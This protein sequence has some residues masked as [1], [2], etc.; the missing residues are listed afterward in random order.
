DLI[1]EYIDDLGDTIPKNSKIGVVA[2]GNDYMV[3]NKPG[4]KIKSV[5]EALDPE[6]VDEPIDQSGTDI[7]AALEYTGTLFTDDVIKRI[8][9]ISDGK[10]TNKSNIVGV[11][12]KLTK[13]DIYIDAIYLDNNIKEESNEIQINQIEYTKSTYLN[14]E[15]KV[16]ALV[17][18]SVEANAVMTLQ[19]GEDSKQIAIT[20]NEGFNVINVELDTKTAGEKDYILSI[21]SANETHDTSPYNNAYQFTQKVAEKVEMLFVSQNKTEEAKI[22]ELYGEVA[23]IDIRINKAIPYTIDELVKYDIFV[24]SNVDVRELD[25]ATE[26]LKN[27]DICVSQYGKSLVTMGNTYIQ[28]NENDDLSSLSTL[29]PTNYGN[30]DQNNRALGIVIDVSRSMQT[31][32]RIHM[33]KQA[34]CAT[35]DLLNEEDM[36]FVIGFAGSIKM[37]HSPVYATDEFKVAIKEAIMSA[38][39]SQGTFM[40]SSL[41]EAYKILNTMNFKN[42]DIMLFSDGKPYGG[43]ATDAEFMAGTIGKANISI[44]TVNTGCDDAAAVKLMEKVASIANGKSYFIEEL[45]D[46]DKL[47]LN[48]VANDIKDSIIQGGS[49]EVN[50]DRTSDDL[51]DGIKELPNISGYYFNSIKTSAKVILSTKYVTDE[52]TEYNVPI[53]SYWNYG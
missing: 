24:L 1:D 21:Q 16:I 22:K 18:S 20:L 30:D 4:E 26:F 10:E 5:K 39:P 33:A 37:L 15:E 11:V 48:E 47:I 31:L 51:V 43:E 41:N 23:N 27:V 49:Y 38:E 52:E 50:I 45:A 12:E 6:L 34:A 14:R 19:N 53:Y 35:V 25:Y 32:E 36:V 17:Q 2:F 44:S 13:D 9:I 8:V 28:N 7:A 40:G 46:V 3:L 29:L 42:K